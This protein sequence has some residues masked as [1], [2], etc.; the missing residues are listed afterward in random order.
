MNGILLMA[1]H[2]A[3][4]G[5]F[6]V[7]LIVYLWTMTLAWPLLSDFNLVSLTDRFRAFGWALVAISLAGLPPLVGFVGKGMVFWHSLGHPALLAVAHVP[8]PRAR[9][10]GRGVGHHAAA[11]GVPFLVGLDR[12]LLAVCWP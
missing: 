4:N 1:I 12:A 8:Q 5:A 7:N 6:W 2:A 10:A 3:E 9:S 11:D